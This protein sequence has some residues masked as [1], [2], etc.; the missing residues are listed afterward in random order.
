MM[1][2]PLYD[3]SQDE[4][5]S[6][7]CLD[8]VEQGCYPRAKEIDE[9]LIQM[10]KKANFATALGNLD[11]GHAMKG[12]KLGMNLFEIYDKLIIPHAKKIIKENKI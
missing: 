6:E 2:E 3:D 8:L 5:I 12:A 4:L 7:I 11:F 9:E 1:E 10:T